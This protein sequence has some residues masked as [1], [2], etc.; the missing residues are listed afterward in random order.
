MDEV[1]TK[2]G[3][4]WRYGEK[5]TL[6]EADKVAKEHGYEYVEDM[7]KALEKADRDSRFKATLTADDERTG[8]KKGMVF[9]PKGVYW[10]KKNVILV[11]S[12][13]ADHTVRLSFKADIVKVEMS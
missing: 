10:H 6:P 4:L 8:Y 13:S 11:G 1:T 5:I 9:H 7:V 2:N 12:V 3:L